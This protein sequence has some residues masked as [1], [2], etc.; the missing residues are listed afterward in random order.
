MALNP[1][2]IIALNRAVAVSKVQGPAAGLAELE[3]IQDHASLKGYNLYYATRGELYSQ[4]G[5]SQEAADCY[6][7]ALHLTCS[8]PV[9]RFI[10]RRLQTVSR[11][12][13]R[14]SGTKAR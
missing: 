13:C 10:F 7:Q 3:L 14:G 9:R 4:L 1:P 8:E 2:P 11:I 12:S 5:Q 6:Q